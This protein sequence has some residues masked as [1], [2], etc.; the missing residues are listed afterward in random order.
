MDISY[1]SKPAPDARSLWNRRRV[2]KTILVL[3][4]IAF[5][6]PTGLFLAFF[7]PLGQV[8]DE[9]A[10]V[11]R[12]ESLLHGEFAGHRMPGPVLA[13]GPVEL[14][15]FVINAAPFAV[16]QLSETVSGTQKMTAGILAQLESIPWASRLSFIGAPNTAV[17]F[18]IFYV[19]GAAGMAFGRLEG[20]TPFGAILASRVAN[21]IA[22]TIM[23]VLALAL[24]QRGWRLMFAAL[25][26]PM[27]LS[28]AASCNQDGLLIASSCLAAALLT[29]AR[30][31]RGRSYWAAAALI[32]C[33]IAVKPAYLPMAA[34]MILPCTRATRRDVLSA[35]AAMA[36]TSLPGVIWALVMMHAVS[37]PFIWGPPYHPGPLWPGDPN[38]LF[39]G[40]DPAAQARVLLHHPLLILTQPLQTIGFNGLLDLQQAVGVLGNLTVVMAPPLYTYWFAAVVMCALGDLLAS[41]EAARPNPALAWIGLLAV[42]A[43]VIAIF[44]LEYLTWTKV[45]D[46]PIILGVQGRYAIPLLP[47]IAIALPLLRLPYTGWLRTALGVP[48]IALAALGAVYLPGLVLATYYL[49]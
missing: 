28:L 3:L 7:V 36:L 42:V 48:A 12:I 17:Y 45:G 11:V 39:A 26:L 29:R 44:D 27:T 4:L 5:V 49:H 32:A 23:A 43:T 24:A 35:G 14:S 10:H 19:P 20:L 30:G 9:P 38:R 18:P 37:A 41:P 25:T 22:Y 8:P 16:T 46:G 21:I 2:E 1:S 31:P 15:G 40:S 13:T 33:I 47:M 6:V 34:I